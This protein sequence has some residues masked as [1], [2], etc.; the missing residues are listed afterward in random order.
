MPR[1]D[2]AADR[3]S[4]ALARLLLVAAVLLAATG[5]AALI[6]A[7]PLPGWVRAAV[8]LDTLAVAIYAFIRCLTPRPAYRPFGS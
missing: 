5:Q 6:L 3:F 4:A 1:T 7:V 8:L 2:L